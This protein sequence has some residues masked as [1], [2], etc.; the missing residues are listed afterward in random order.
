MLHRC[1]APDYIIVIMSIGEFVNLPAL[2]N[3]CRKQMDSPLRS[4]PCMGKGKPAWAFLFI[5]VV[6]FKIHSPNLTVAQ[7]HTGS[8]AGIE[9][10]G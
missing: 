4:F 9:Q 7:P 5:A 10:A 6:L 2:A 3:V 8:S 1:T